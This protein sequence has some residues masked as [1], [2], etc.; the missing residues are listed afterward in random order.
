MTIKITEN[1]LNTILEALTQAG[2]N[3]LRNNE[4]NNLNMITEAYDAL[5]EVPFKQ[6]FIQI[7]LPD[8][9]MF[10]KHYHVRNLAIKEGKEIAMGKP[11]KLVYFVEE[12]TETIE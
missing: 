8:G 11:F 12:K 5:K 2:N 3:A 6:S 4:Q 10:Q 1:Q 7:E 9:R